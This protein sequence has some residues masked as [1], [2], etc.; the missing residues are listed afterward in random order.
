MGEVVRQRKH[1]VVNDYVKGNP[2]KKGYPKGHVELDRFMSVPVIINEKIVAVIGMANKQNEYSDNDV[3]NLTLLMSGTWQDIQRREVEK[4]LS[5]ERNKYFQTLIS[6]GDGIMVVD[7]DGKVEMLNYVAEKLTGWTN[8]EAHGRNY[9][10]VFKL[11]SESSEKK[12]ATPL[13]LL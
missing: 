13:K 10:D 4:Q 1:I 11:A 6:I 2:L 8:E 7:L 12:Y 3:F 9:K 5:Y